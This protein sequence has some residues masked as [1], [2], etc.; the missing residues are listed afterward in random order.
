VRHGSSVRKLLLASC[1]A[2]TAAIAAGAARPGTGA[3]FPAIT[4]PA[5]DAPLRVTILFMCN[6]ARSVDPWEARIR[7]GRDVEWVLD[8]A[9]DATDFRI[10]RKKDA[11][12]WPFDGAAPHNGR[13][14]APARGKGRARTP[15]GRYSY[16]IE[17]S[18]RTP[19]GGVEWKKIDPDIIV[20][21]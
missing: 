19:A 7:S 13:K 17:A 21:I 11:D 2:A 20:D 4:A 3:R 8:P 14:G 15:R 10:R 18:C 9:S 6:G 1:L 16:D 12:P 5:Q